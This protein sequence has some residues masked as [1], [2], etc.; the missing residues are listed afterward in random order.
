[1]IK[2][3]ESFPSVTVK[4]LTADGMA[5]INTAELLKGKKVVLFAVPGAFTPT[6][7][8]RHLPGYVDHA[9]ALKAAGVDAI[10]CMAV[11]D[12]FVMKAWGEHSKAN[13]AVTM[14]P[15]GNGAITKALGLEFDLSGPNLGLRSHRFSMLIDNGVV[16]NIQLDKDGGFEVSGAE[17]MLKV[18]KG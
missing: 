16:K 1:M 12:P 15:D 18:L 10:I 4:H 7:S 13:E 14:L 6:C 9:A 11:N 2:V 5:E 8:A 3:G 17:T